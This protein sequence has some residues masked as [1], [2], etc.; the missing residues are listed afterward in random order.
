M[1][2]PLLFRTSSHWLES[3]QWFPKELEQT[4]SV[5]KGSY[6]SVL[7][8]PR[9]MTSLGAV[10]G[11]GAS[12]TTAET[13]EGKHVPNISSLNGDGIRVSRGRDIPVAWSSGMDCSKELHALPVDPNGV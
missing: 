9:V 12:R 1:W 3:W 5:G 4:L 6:M 10:E 2:E 11:F 7:T 13:L 8:P